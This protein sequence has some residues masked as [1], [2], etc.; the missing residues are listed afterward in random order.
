MGIGFRVAE[1][2]CLGDQ[3]HS[4]SRSEACIALLERLKEGLSQVMIA[5]S[6]CFLDAQIR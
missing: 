6:L 3:G 4:V 1:R 5:Y 2:V